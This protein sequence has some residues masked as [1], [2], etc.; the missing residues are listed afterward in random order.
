MKKL[1]TIIVF[2][3]SVIC[4]AQNLYTYF[5]IDNGQLVYERIYNIDSI[6]A[7][8]IDTL[9][10]QQL[11]TAK[12][13]T[14]VQ[15]NNGA[16]TCS[17]VDLIVNYKKYGGT[18]MGTAMFLNDPF[19]ANV[20][21]QIKEGKYKITVTN[22]VFNLVVPTAYGIS[23]VKQAAETTFLKNSSTEFKTRDKLIEAGKYMELQFND[24]FTIKIIQKTDW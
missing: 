18:A 23:H 15:S 14:N 11:P 17:I 9:L 21:I 3:T 20:S 22:I 2:L 16:I 12:G 10:Q 6:A 1:I 13:I 7:G 24:I 8:K 19:T 5:K 4:Y